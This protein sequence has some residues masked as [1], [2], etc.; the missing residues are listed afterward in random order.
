MLRSKLPNYLR[1]YR[2]RSYLS[3]DE[4]AYLLGCKDGARVSRY[5]NFSR[6][7]SPEAI[8]AYEIIFHLPARELFAGHYLKIEKNVLKRAQLLARKTSAV[9]SDAITRR[10]LQALKAISGSENEPKKI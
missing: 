5:E 9:N 2:K 6:R 7:P 10:K 4:V 3:Q 8:F 1:T